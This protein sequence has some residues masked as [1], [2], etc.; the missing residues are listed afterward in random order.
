MRIKTKCYL[1]MLFIG[2]NSNP[3]FG[4]E[5]TQEKIFSNLHGIKFAE[6]TSYEVE[7]YT[8]YTKTISAQLHGAAFNKT[9][10]RLNIPKDAV[11][12]TD[13]TLVTENKVYI[14]ESTVLDK[15]SQ[16]SIHYFIKE[17]KKHIT[18]FSFFTNGKRDLELEKLLLESLSKKT[19]PKNIYSS[20]TFDSVLFVGRFI[21]PG[22]ICSWRDAHNIQCPGYGQ[23]NW[24]QFR[25]LE[26]AQ[27]V[28]E[29]QKN[30]VLISN[31]GTILSQDSVDIIFEGVDVRALK[32]KYKFGI[33]QIIMGG[34][35]ILIIYFVMAEVRNKF[36]SCVLSHYTDDYNAQNLPPLLSK[37]MQLK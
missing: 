9:K 2:F 34:S 37:V 10:K 15:I 18:L 13:S 27:E 26:R 23:M 6:F 4:Q 11:E 8:I 35:N 30:I 36:V 17:N 32:I 28:L 1:T 16:I 20:Q 12:T 22:S 21:T 33:P 19:I 24:S 25:S 29:C 14:S 7:G 3:I 31:N 5:T